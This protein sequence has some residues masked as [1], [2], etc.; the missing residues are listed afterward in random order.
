MLVTKDHCYIND[1]FLNRNDQLI[2]YLIH[3]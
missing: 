1:D 3:L 2:N